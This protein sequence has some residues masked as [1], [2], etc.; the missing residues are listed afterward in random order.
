[1]KSIQ[2]SF[3]NIFSCPIICVYAWLYYSVLVPFY[4]RLLATCNISCSPPP[5]IIIDMVWLRKWNVLSLIHLIPFYVRN[6]NIY[7]QF[8][9]CLNNPLTVVSRPRQDGH[10]ESVITCS[11]WGTW[12]MADSRENKMV[13]IDGC[14]DNWCNYIGYIFLTGCKVCKLGC[15]VSIV[16][17]PCY[18]CKSYSKLYNK[19]ESKKSYEINWDW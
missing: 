12:D 19:G 13:C 7:Q 15:N 16:T 14:R 8:A 5:P 18:K 9:K 4:L 3:K 17:S 11:K 2:L 1:M 10:S 6:T